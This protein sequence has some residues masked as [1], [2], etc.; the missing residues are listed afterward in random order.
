MAASGNFAFNNPVFQE[1]RPG[2]TPPAAQ[3][4]SAAA[5]H[6]AAAVA[7]NAQLEGMFAAPTASSADTGRMTVEDT[8]VKT[9][10]LFGILLVTALVGWFWTLGG[11]LMPTQVQPGS[12][13][14]APWIIG[15]FVGFILA[16]VITFTS[17]KKVRPALVWAYAAAEGLFVGGISAFFEFIWP[18]VVLQATV[19]T[20]VVVGVTLALFASGKVRVSKKAN[21]IFMIAMVSYLVFGLVNL[22]L[23]WTGVT[24]G[25]FGLYSQ[26]IFGIP[27]G[28]VIGLLVVLM[29]SYSLVQDFDLVQQ[30][31][32]NGAPREFGWIGAFGIMVT[33][34]WLYVEILRMI[35]ILRGSN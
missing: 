7:S 18:G 31:A 16:L 8:V 5:S 3:T 24:G 9:A 13:T 2:L 14:M 29:A 15:A 6:Q 32:R 28:L 19:A 12:L 23:M 34:V 30:G 17:R 21:K 1:Q 11:S 4:N 35:A 25:T 22:V 20:L 27:L 33:V 26:K 10:G